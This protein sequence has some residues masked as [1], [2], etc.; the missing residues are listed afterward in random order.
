MTLSIGVM[1]CGSGDAATATTA[2]PTTT[3]LAAVTTTSAGGTATT[4]A[5]SVTVPSVQATPELT[6][7]LAQIQVV[8][9]TVASLADSADPTKI[10]DASQ[11]T[12]AQIK[13]AEAALAEIRTALDQLK[14]LKPPAELAAFQAALVAGIATEVDIVS[15]AIDALKNKDQAA[16]DAAK[17]SASQLE[18]QMSAILDQLLPLMGGTPTS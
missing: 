1:A 9:A 7:Y 15:K 11:V 8:F 18:T 12:D 16:L 13:A 17:A 4:A 3:T 6:S 2:A 14:A 10:A 5:G